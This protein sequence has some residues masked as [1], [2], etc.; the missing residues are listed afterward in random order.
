MKLA[1]FL[2]L[3]AAGVAEGSH[4]AVLVPLVRSMDVLA[5]APSAVNG[6]GSTGFTDTF[7]I[8]W[9]LTP[10]ELVVMMRCHIDSYCSVGFGKGVLGADASVAYNAGNVTTWTENPAL[11]TVAVVASEQGDG[12]AEED[13]HFATFVF[14]LAGLPPN[15]TAKV[16]H[17]LVAW[18]TGRAQGSLL[19]DSLSGA[20]Y[21]DWT[22]PSTIAPTAAPT[23]IPLPVPIPTLIPG[24]AGDGGQFTTRFGMH[25]E[26][27]PTDVIITMTCATDQY[28]AVALGN[29]KLEADTMVCYVGGDVHTYV[30]ESD[31]VAN[32]NVTIM[33]SGPGAVD[34]TWVVV[35]KRSLRPTDYEVATQRMVWTTGTLEGSI[36]DTSIHGVQEVDWVAKVLAPP[37][38]TIAPVANTSAP[39]TLAPGDTHAPGTAAPNTSEPVTVPEDGDPPNDSKQLRLFEVDGSLSFG[40]EF[41]AAAPGRA[42]VAQADLNDTDS[43]RFTFVCKTGRY[44]ALGL[45]ERGRMIASD[46]IT[47]YESA[48]EGG[49]VCVDSYCTERDACPADAS[50]DIVRE[51][52]QRDG[53]TFSVTVTRLMYTGDV[54]DAEITPDLLR[55]IYATGD[56]AGTPPTKQH[57]SW[58]AA[59]YDVL[60]EELTILSDDSTWQVPAALGSFV[61]LGIVSGVLT[62]SS[63]RLG[64][65]F[66]QHWFASACSIV[67]ISAAIA[68]VMIGDYLHYA[69]RLAQ[70]AM[71]W[72]GP[73]QVCLAL[74]VVLGCRAASPARLLLGVPEG[75]ALVW[76]R[77]IARLGWLLATAHLLT[78]C[79]KYAA[80]PQGTPA[81]FQQVLATGYTTDGERKV[82]PLAGFIGWCAYTLFI[83]A[84][85]PLLSRINYRA[86]SISQAVLSFVTVVC[87]VVHLPYGW[88][89]Y[90]IFAVPVLLLLAEYVM[91][92]VKQCTHTAKI[93]SCETTDT[94]SR[95]AVELRGRVRW[96][97]GSYFYLRVPAISAVQLHP[98]AVTSH[99]TSGKAVFYVKNTG[100]DKW[101]NFDREQVEGAAVKLEGP[102]GGLSLDMHAYR[103]M[104]LFAGG[105]GITHALSILTHMEPV[106]SAL[107][108]WT[109]RDANLIQLVL[110][111]L[112]EVVNR[113]LNLQ[114]VVYYTGLE[115]LEDSGGG[116]LT[117]VAGRP[118]F[119]EVART[120]VDNETAVS[121]CG[122]SLMASDVLQSLRKN[123]LSVPVHVESFSL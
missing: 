28:C 76:H 8:T 48:A 82:R 115:L 49:P 40:V 20:L 87:V 107:L 117:Y 109:V 90:V 6:A 94:M 34:G 35:F 116:Q 68:I 70:T 3:A 64:Y 15:A 62:R 2:W 23:P 75:S 13:V 47:C 22:E 44:C 9:D 99:Y 54:R 108:V 118:F 16:K 84:G 105:V 111:D 32:V 83:I 59:E 95:V 74:A 24:S 110:Q 69:G 78:L 60:A 26:L 79:V 98:F 123:K 4:Q 55:L 61:A 104:V 30:G 38:D 57:D 1:C 72:G 112:V 89:S 71:L 103:K 66:R 88:R 46:V 17:Q 41:F 10:A 121:I 14:A 58:G 67:V 5:Q 91:R 101:T 33:S 45:S 29:T 106:K 53:G 51:S 114:V 119:G 27:T 85:T 102:Y 31:G 7:S 39:G 122:P 36:V 18:G 42:A 19:T 93:V 65:F 80:G 52:T 86:Y 21:L 11:Q 63:Q 12:E 50:Q 73:A 100:R 120:Y 56:A 97:P 92:A 81:L 96:G 113:L 43:V 77:W 37:Q 25:W